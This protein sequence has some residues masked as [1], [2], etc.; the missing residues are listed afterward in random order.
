[1]NIYS[2]FEVSADREEGKGVGGEEKK[3]HTLTQRLHK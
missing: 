2:M 1:M 3:Y